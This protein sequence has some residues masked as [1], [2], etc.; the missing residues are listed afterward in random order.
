MRFLTIYEPLQRC[1]QVLLLAVQVPDPDKLFRFLKVRFGLLCQPQK[2][3]GVSTLGILHLSIGLQ[4][5]QPVLAN[6][7]Q[8][9]ETRFS[10]LLLCL[11]QEA[12]VY[13]GG[14]RIQCI[15]LIAAAKADGFRRLEGTP[16][17][18]DRES[19]KEPLLLL[20]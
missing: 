4:A 2:V 14:E 18:E 16:A 13:E 9:R 8:H 17:D 20:F 10:A 15:Y 6:G 7:L 19:L 1:S 12:F 11:S 3:L 5:F